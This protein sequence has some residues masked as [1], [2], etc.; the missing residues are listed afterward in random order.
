VLASND[1]A[2]RLYRSLGFE[3]RRTMAFGVFAR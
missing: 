2:L 3:A 1:S